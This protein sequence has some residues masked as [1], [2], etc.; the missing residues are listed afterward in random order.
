MGNY[1]KPF[2]VRVG[3]RL[4]DVVPAGDASDG[5]WVC[6]WGGEERSFDD[7]ADFAALAPDGDW[8]T[9]DF[10]TFAVHVRKAASRVE[11]RAEAI[12]EGTTIES[13][14]H[15]DEEAALWELANAVAPSAVPRACFFC[16]YSEVEKSAGWGH[17]CCNVAD[18]KSYE[19]W[20]SSPGRTWPLLSGKWVDEW[21]GCDEW[22]VRPRGH[23]YRGG[24]HLRVL[25]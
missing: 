2:R 22:E 18:K 8:V 14:I 23:G 1:T 11:Y 7:V 21:D 19:A 5:P 6:Q 10:G 16:R 9:C 25:S 4:A 17:L 24:G 20:A 3:D 12:I 15:H 13:G